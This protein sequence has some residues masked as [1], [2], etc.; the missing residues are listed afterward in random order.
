MHFNKKY[1]IWLIAVSL[2]ASCSK[3]LNQNPQSSATRDVVFGSPDGLQLYANSFYDSLPGINDLYK[4][5]GDI[6]DYGAENAIPNLIRPNSF[7]SRQSSGWSWSK[8]RN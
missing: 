7:G 4:K 8:L 6:S 5:D 2:L 1:F 3:N